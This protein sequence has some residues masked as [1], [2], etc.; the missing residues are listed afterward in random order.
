MNRTPVAEQVRLKSPQDIERM[1]AAGRVVAIVLRQVAAAVRPGITTGELDEMAERLIT[2]LGA[3]P[4]FKGY[5]NYPA[6]LCVS[7][8][9]EV[10]HGIPG[11]RVLN[12]GDIASLDV[13]AIVDGFYADAARTVAVGTVSPQA[14]R[15][16]RVAREALELG[17]AQA[18]PGATIGDIATAVERHVERNGYSVVRDLSGHGIGRDMH[19]SP[20]VP[21]F[22]S[23]ASRRQLRFAI[24]AGV[25]LAIEPMVNEGG[26]E[27]VK[28][29]DGWT[30][31]T[32][33]GSLSAHFEHTIAVQE[34]GPEILTRL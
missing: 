25:T 13:G 34:S 20:Q 3:K 33:D 8:N 24:E 15:L 23:G 19:E 18:R 7:V 6:T 28:A 31:R 32:R 17:I 5:G 4:A 16:M 14:K 27:I 26:P 11:E 1:G 22:T 29:D 21:N 2:E 9:D 30:Y 10:V 12:A